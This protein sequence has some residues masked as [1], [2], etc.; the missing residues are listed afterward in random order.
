MI[1]SSSIQNSASFWT[2]PEFTISDSSAKS[3]QTVSIRKPTCWIIIGN[4]TA[5]R[6]C[7]FGLGQMAWPKIWVWA[8]KKISH[9]YLAYCC[10]WGL[11]CH[12]GTAA[13]CWRPTAASHSFEECSIGFSASIASSVVEQ[14][15]SCA[16]RL[17]SQR[18]TSEWPFTISQQERYKYAWWRRISSHWLLTLLSVMSSHFP[19]GAARLLLFL[20]LLY[21][22]LPLAFQN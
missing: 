22:M 18:Q 3:S 11:V 8:S 9:S 6:L 16:T 15:C 20:Y 10:C 1:C 14:S 5:A 7:S 17:V 4:A 13:A 2:S 21:R 19:A 12:I